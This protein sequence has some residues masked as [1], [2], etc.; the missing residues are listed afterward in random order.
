MWLGRSHLVGEIQN[1]RSSSP[2]KRIS[3]KCSHMWFGL[4]ITYTLTVLHAHWIRHVYAFYLSTLNQH[5]V[6]PL[7]SHCVWV[8]AQSLQSCLTLCEPVDCSLPGSS[9]HGILQAII[10]KWAAIASSRGSS[11]PRDWTHISYVS[12]VGRWVLYHQRHL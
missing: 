3:F 10:L 9:V 11:R 2:A 4:R 8:R 1:P 7:P 12:Y 5:D 6:L